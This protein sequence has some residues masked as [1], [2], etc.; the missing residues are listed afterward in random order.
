MV[1]LSAIVLT[2]V[3]WRASPPFG[4][5]ISSITFVAYPADAFK[6][7]WLRYLICLTLP[8][9]A[10]PGNAILDCRRST[11]SRLLSPRFPIPMSSLF[12]KSRF[13]ICAVASLFPLVLSFP[14]NAQ[15]T[16]ARALREQV[17]AGVDREYSSLE[18][19]YQHLHANPELSFHEEKTAR[20]IA[21][22]LKQ[23][24]FTVTEKIGGHGVIGIFRNGSGP[25]ILLRTDLD[26]LP[27]KEQT[28]LSYASQAKGTNE[29]GET[30]D[31]MHACGHDMHM[32]VFVGTARLLAGLKDQWQG[33]LVMVGQP[34]EE[35]AKGARRMIEA[36][37]FSRFPKPDFCLALHCNANLPT[38]TMGYVE[39][40]AMAN[41]DML[42][43]TIRGKGGH[44]AWPQTTKDPIVL[45]AQAILAFQTIVSRE[46]AP[47]DPAVVTVGAI[48][49]GTKHNIIPNE[50]QL[51]LTLRSYSD[52]VRKSQIASI[53]RILRGLA[54][55]AGI[56]EDL[57]PTV[58]IRDEFTPATYN[59]P[60]LSR[61]IAGVMQ[62]W[63]GADRVSKVKPVMGGEDFSEFGRTP[64]KLP[65]CLLWLG[66][67]EP[68]SYK[69]HLASGKPLPSLH[70]SQFFPAVAP[71]IKTGV[72]VMTAAVLDLAGK[73]R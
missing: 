21:D 66:V 9:S 36:G 55:A 19:L 24:G 70:S 10:G 50:V 17:E 64:D 32:T 63:L 61:R 44:G 39:G 56:P 31:V 4:A 23:A 41:V 57:H 42:D 16:P 33:T 58:T 15:P 3:D 49:G 43:V 28:G 68:D 22:E 67:V 60:D 45:A 20:R 54:E 53:K 34:A 26:A 30:V 72:T 2:S 46:T 73:K 25:T 47:T 71:T 69:E 13:F 27:V 12:M 14:T 65:I 52:E 7:A 8:V 35:R 38:G 1:I 51:Q 48:H 59:D 5:Q 37:M 40:F 6:T 29:T 18:N 11:L 62:S